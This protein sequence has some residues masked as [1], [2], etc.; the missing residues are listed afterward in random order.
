[1]VDLYAS[2]HTQAVG[3]SN[4]AIEVVFEHFPSVAR[5][6]ATGVKRN[7]EAWFC[8]QQDRGQAPDMLQN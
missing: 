1:M 3:Y 8:I 7:Q 6:M 4:E 2:N 5:V